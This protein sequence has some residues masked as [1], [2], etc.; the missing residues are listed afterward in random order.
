MLLVEWEAEVGARFGEEFEIKL[1]VSDRR[2]EEA[3][4]TIVLVG[5]QWV[6]M[7]LAVAFSKV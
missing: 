5:I 2:E 6:V 4:L 7:A 1:E 3:I